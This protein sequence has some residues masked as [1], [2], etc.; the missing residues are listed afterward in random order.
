MSIAV[1]VQRLVEVGELIAGEGVL[2]VAV[3]IFLPASERLGAAPMVFF[4]MPGG[5]LNS[6]YFNLDLA[7]GDD[8]A[9]SDELGKYNFAL[10][11]AVRGCITVT[12]DHLGIGASSRPSDGFA[13]T[14]EVMVAANAQ[15]VLYVQQALRH[16][17]LLDDLPALPGL[18]SIGVGHSMGGML[19]AMLQAGCRCYDAIAVLGFSTAGL[20]EYLTPADAE[21]VDDPRGAR[22]N[23]VRLA[24]LRSDDPYPDLQTRGQAREIYG[25][26]ADRRALEALRGARDKVLAVMGFFAMLPGSTSDVC[27]QIEAPVFLGVG[28]KDMTGPAHLL[29]ASF[30]GSSDVTLLVLPDTGHTHFIFPS[31]TQLFKRLAD[32]ADSATSPV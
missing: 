28:D 24:K 30:C 27:A 5:G 15:A 26:H 2:R 3:N 4:C 22:A 11:M 32:W 17:A 8:A 13:L 20:P 31:C 25:G 7:A 16:G 19:T 21:F 9:D 1:T 12:V 29:P 23:I 6:R 18:R 14:P 10:Q